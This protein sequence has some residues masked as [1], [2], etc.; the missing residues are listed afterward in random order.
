VTGILDWLVVRQGLTRR[1]YGA[2][3]AGLFVSFATYPFAVPAEEG[4]GF[5]QLRW[6]HIRSSNDQGSG[7]RVSSERI[8]REVSEDRPYHVGYPVTW[9]LL[10]HEE[11]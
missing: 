1:T 5:M 9:R 6:F 11:V 4:G 8:V 2:A 7:V 3:D 10:V